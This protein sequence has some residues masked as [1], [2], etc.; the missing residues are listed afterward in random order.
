MISLNK[1]KLNE[2]CKILELNVNDNIL[3]RFLDI[4]L[5]PGAIIE[6]VLIS[7]AGGISAYSIMGTIIAIRDKD[8]EGV[9]VKY[10]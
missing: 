4:G 9:I 3:K 2:K 10:V 8:V 7:Y 6:K 5:I 1:I